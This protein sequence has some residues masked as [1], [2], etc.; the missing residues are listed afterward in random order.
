MTDR[1]TALRAT[2]VQNKKNPA[3][4]TTMAKQ[5]AKNWWFV[6]KL[7]ENQSTAPCWVPRSDT[8]SANL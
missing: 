6:S 5:S 7:K 2:T 1:G 3:E 4:I 8:L